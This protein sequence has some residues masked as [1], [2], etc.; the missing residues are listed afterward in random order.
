MIINQKGSYKLI[1]VSILYCQR[2]GRPFL[3]V[4]PIPFLIHL[5]LQERKFQFPA[6]L[7]YFDREAKSWLI[8]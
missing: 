5:I 8:N 6:S 3:G 2:S 7:S 4:S 1:C